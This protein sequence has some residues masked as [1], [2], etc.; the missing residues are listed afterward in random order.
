MIPY[1]RCPCRRMPVTPTADRENSP[2][3]EV[4]L[5]NVQELLRAGCRNSEFAHHGSAGNDEPRTRL[6]LCSFMTPTCGSAADLCSGRHNCAIHSQGRRRNCETPIDKIPNTT[7]SP[8]PDPISITETTGVCTVTPV[9]WIQS[10]RTVLSTAGHRVFD[11]PRGWCGAEIGVLAV[12]F[13]PKVRYRSVNF[14][15]G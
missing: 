7:C 4:E 12:V 14:G 1:Q 3:V 2:S 11:W 6:L 10:L 8:P 13:T 9:V 15:R 5:S